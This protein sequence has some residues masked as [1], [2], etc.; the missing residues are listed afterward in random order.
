MNDPIDQVRTPA[1]WI[2]RIL[3]LA[4]I[5]WGLVIVVVATV[6]FDLVEKMQGFVSAYERQSTKGE[7]VTGAPVVP[8]T[9]EKDER[10]FILLE[11]GV[12]S[13]WYPLGWN[14]HVEFDW[15]TRD[16]FADVEFN[17]GELGLHL[18]QGTKGRSWGKPEGINQELKIRFRSQC[19][20]C[21]WIEKSRRGFLLQSLSTQP[22]QVAPT[23]SMDYLDL[24]L[25]RESIRV[26]TVPLDPKDPTKWIRLD[27]SA[28]QCR[29]HSE[30][31]LEYSIIPSIGRRIRVFPETENFSLGEVYSKPFR[32]VGSSPGQTATITLFR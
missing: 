27:P 13:N 9:S 8:Q 29:V 32:L 31:N 17:T 22:V 21:A 19:G 5:V 25:G 23:E 26:F 4:A 7:S 30:P 10:T 11:S 14:N 6:R 24:S 15:D 20:G 3:I 2:G 18:R 28:A 12:W 16:G 1:P